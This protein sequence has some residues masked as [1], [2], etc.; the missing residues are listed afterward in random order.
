MTHPS[1]IGQ[2]VFVCYFSILF[3]SLPMP[4]FS[5]E[6]HSQ[7]IHAKLQFTTA[8][9]CILLPYAL[10]GFEPGVTV[11][12]ALQALSARA[13]TATTRELLI[14]IWGQCFHFHYIFAKFLPI[15]TE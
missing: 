10:A 7:T 14:H 13:S 11:P 8:L 15:L 1:K 2:I 3:F 4:L 12:R 6:R 5:T 9:H